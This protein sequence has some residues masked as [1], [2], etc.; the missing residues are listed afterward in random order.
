MTN[1]KSQESE[2]LEFSEQET[3]ARRDAALK[4]ALTTP[5]KPHAPLK[6][7]VMRIESKKAG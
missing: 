1:R 5:H 7:G 6:R 3:A 4:R 2:D